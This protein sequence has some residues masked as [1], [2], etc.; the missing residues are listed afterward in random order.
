MCLTAPL[1]DFNSAPAVKLIDLGLSKSTT[2]QSAAGTL[3]GTAYYIAPEVYAAGRALSKGVKETYDPFKADTWALGVMLLVMLFVKYPLRRRTPDGKDQ[4]IATK[5]LMDVGKA[6]AARG[7]L[8]GKLLEDLS[9]TYTSDAGRDF[10]LRC[11]TLDPAQRPT[12][13]ELLQDPWVTAG[14]PYPQV[15]SARMRSFCRCAV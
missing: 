15:G 11:F 6:M 8:H 14:E 10:I 2:T 12:P 9:M 4:P 7:E 13:A 1:C 3:L 5:F